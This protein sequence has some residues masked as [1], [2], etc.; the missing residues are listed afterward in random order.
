MASFNMC[1]VL[2]SYAFIILWQRFLG[3]GWNY[4]PIVPAPDDR[5]L[6]WSS[7]WNENWHGKPKYSEKTCPSATLFTTNPTWPDLGSNLGRRGGKLATNRLSYGTAYDK[8]LYRYKFM[9]M[10]IF[11]PLFREVKFCDVPSCVLDK[12]GCAAGEKRFWQ[13]GLKVNSDKSRYMYWYVYVSSPE[14]KTKS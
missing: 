10:Y 8:D 14:C 11:L 9:T 13:Q 5:W 3:V 4:W 1:Y 12:L 7:R 6:V 2:F